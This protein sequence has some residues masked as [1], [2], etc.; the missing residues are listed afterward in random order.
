MCLSSFCFSNLHICVLHNLD[1]AGL[2]TDRISN[3]KLVL[4]HTKYFY[5]RHEHVMTSIFRLI[6]IGQPSF[7]FMVPNLNTRCQLLV[8][9]IPLVRSL[10]LVGFEA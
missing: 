8:K 3:E 4:S 2:S 7:G 1:I 5:V 10:S 6:G 9:L